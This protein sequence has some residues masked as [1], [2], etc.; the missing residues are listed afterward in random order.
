[1]KEKDSACLKFLKCKILSGINSLHYT[2]IKGRGESMR[3]WHKQ[4]DGTWEIKGTTFPMW[5]SE[6]RKNP[7][8]TYKQLDKNSI[9]LLDLVEYESKNKT[10]KIKGTD[11][12]SDN[13]F[14]WRGIGPL[15]ILSSRWQVVTIKG[16]VMVIRFEKSL[17]TPA[18]I[19]VLVRKG[20]QIPDLMERILTNYEAFGLSKTEKNEL[21]W[22]NDQ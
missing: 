21:Q 3:T 8:I 13:Q 22:L 18:G 17:V 11:R 20:S 19:D 6:K 16:D 10:K 4:L 15:K 12:V 14:V 5:L 7:R 2:D 9:E 1:M